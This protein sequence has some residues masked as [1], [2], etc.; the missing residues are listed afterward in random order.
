MSTDNRKS[1]YERVPKA[2]L[3]LHLTGAIPHQTLWELIQKYGGDPSVP[4]FSSL[5]KKFEYRDFMHF[6]DTWNWKNQF[7]R[8]YEDFTFLSEAVARDLADQNVLYAEVFFSSSRFANKNIKTQKLAEAIRKGLSRVPEIEINLIVDLVRDN[9]PE[10]ADRILPDII[11]A[12]EFGIIGIGLG[13]AEQLYPQELFVDVFE[14]ARQAG[15]HT[16]AHAGEAAGPESIRGAVDSLKVERIGHGTRAVEDERLVDYL[17]EHSIP[18]EICLL[19][20][21]KTGIVET[22][23]KHPVRYYYDRNIPISINTDDPKMFGNSLAQEFETLSTVF[24][25][26]RDEIRTLLFNA[27]RTSWLPEDKKRELAG[28]LINHPD[29]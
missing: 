23:E 4:D 28:R 22:V 1:W 8:E 16:T 6:L 11:E 21:V 24:G 17:A 19:S 25:F 18:I 7:L 2:E 27:V 15:L 20:N 5:E 9:G 13:G 3:H 14:K 26:I 12:K 29:W 10:N